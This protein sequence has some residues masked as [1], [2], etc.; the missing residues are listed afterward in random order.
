MIVESR[1]VLTVAVL[2][3]AG[4]ACM[5][6]TSPAFAQEPPDTA[7]LALPQ[8]GA[9]DV[10]DDFTRL[11]ELTGAR[12]L[13]SQMRHR[14]ITE[15]PYACPDRDPIGS[16]WYRP[17]PAPGSIIDG[18]PLRAAIVANNRY[19]RSFNDGG[20]WAGRGFSTALEGGARFR[21]GVLSAVI[22]PAVYTAQNRRFKTPAVDIARL[23]EFA[24]PW[25]GGR[26]DWPVRP[27]DDATANLDPGQSVLR[28]DAYGAVLGVSNENIWWGPSLFNPLMFSNTGPGFRH[29]F[30]GTSRPA[31]IYIGHLEAEA[32]WGVLDESEYYDN[33]PDNDDRALAGLIVSF[34][35]RGLDGL[36][37]GLARTY[38]AIL[39]DDWTVGDFFLQPY[40][41]PRNNPLRD[42]P[43]GDDQMLALYL[44]WALPRSGFEAYA[45]WG[46]S[47]HWE[48]LEDLLKE[49]DHAQAYALG[50]QKVIESGDT[51]GGPTRWIRIYGELTHLE[52]ALPIR[53]FRGAV[54]FYTHSQ[55]KQGWT[56]RGQLLGA[57]IGPGSDAQ[58]IGADVF[59]SWGRI[60]GYIQRVRYD[61]D[62]YYA[63]FSQLYSYHGH[64]SELTGAVR[65][66]LIHDDFHVQAE[67][68]YSNRFN[69]NFLNHHLGDFAGL[70]SERNLGLALGVSWQPPI[71]GLVPTGG[72][73]RTDR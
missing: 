55:V 32:L 66:L 46:R 68:T 9:R 38:M 20:L 41:S 13:R 7:C 28:V 48:D 65:G 34:Q 44:R 26:I 8:P 19:P 3:V 61:D 35:P 25:H 37:L 63:N 12:P 53:A 40:R 16:G 29:I 17:A 11:L 10:S 70:F 43:R 31:D 67:V 64:D 58:I 2:A 72:P 33:D 22:A 23:S 60:G 71:G 57:G 5:T 51:G 21:Y 73:P 24:Y 14:G 62:A 18:L 4:I 6:S 1:T 50:F 39:E 52:A 42:E 49:P 30:L 36:F 69:R 47:D 27:G 56:Q 45:E 15:R 54:T 59:S